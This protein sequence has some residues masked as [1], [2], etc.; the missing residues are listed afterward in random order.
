MNASKPTKPLP[1]QR[2][3]ALGVDTNYYYAGDRSGSSI[4]LLHGMSTSGDS[5]RELMFDLSDDYFLVA[6]DIPGFGHSQDT[7][8]YTLDH[9][10]E[11][12][13]A[14]IDQLGLAPINLIGH[15]FGGIVASAYV[16]GYPED[17]EKLLLFS[18][19]LLISQQIPPLALK[20]SESRKV[21]DAGI[22]LSRLLLERQ[23]RIQF[24]E[25]E[26]M[27]EGVWQR[28]RDD[29]SRARASAAAVNAVASVDLTPR[30][31]EISQP[32]LVLWGNDDPILTAPQSSDLER[33]FKRGEV[34]LLEQCGHV[35]MLERRD[36]V[37]KLSREFIQ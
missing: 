7:E 9:L 14:F 11:W 16:L 3:D 24:Y 28:R 12:L 37:S 10:I 29:Y 4:V 35:P 26:R 5:F 22:A 1:R 13:A 25:P 23:I 36:E 8:P 27:D 18:P 6:P 32:T 30:L 19:A 20:M 31:S 17:I 21:A 2:V 34:R 33:F 15:S